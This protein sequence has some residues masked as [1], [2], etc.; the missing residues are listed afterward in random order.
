MDLFVHDSE[1][2]LENQLFEFRLAFHHLVANGLLLAS[3]ITWSPAFEQFWPEV[4]GRARRHFMDH[5]LALVI[6]QGAG[7]GT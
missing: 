5:N 4:R 3:D 6:K 2:S 7:A 1:H